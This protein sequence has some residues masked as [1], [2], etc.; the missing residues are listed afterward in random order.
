MLSRLHGWSIYTRPKSIAPIQ[1]KLT[2]VHGPW[3]A[4]RHL[5]LNLASKTFL[6][7][8]DKIFIKND[9]LELEFFK[10]SSKVRVTGRLFKRFLFIFFEICSW[11][12]CENKIFRSFETVHH[13]RLVCVTW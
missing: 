1:K 3:T 11:S 7:L 2:G 13:R 8:S 9:S 5:D 12:F 10:A 4:Q 6:S